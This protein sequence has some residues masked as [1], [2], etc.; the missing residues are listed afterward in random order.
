MIFKDPTV[1]DQ[2]K[3]C[4]PMLKLI[5]YEFERKSLEFG[6]T[7]VMTRLVGMI[8]GDSGV[9]SSG[10]AADFRDEFQDSFMYTTEERAQIIWHI[11]SLFP[12][13]DEHQSIKHH[14][15]NHGP[16]HFHVQVSPLISVYRNMIFPI[17]E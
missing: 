2:F 10:R 4:C 17:Y 12:R 8:D 3:R 14:S 9:H 5:C 16:F 1:E 6:K 15:H 7:P 13:T 11:L